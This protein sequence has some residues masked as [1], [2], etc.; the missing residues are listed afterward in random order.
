MSLERMV[1][2][3]S[4]A[5]VGALQASTWSHV[6]A[7]S[8][9]APDAMPTGRSQFLRTASRLGGGESRCDGRDRLTRYLSL[10]RAEE[11]AEDGKSGPGAD[12]S[13]H[14][15]AAT[16][17]DFTR[18]LMRLSSNCAMPASTAGRGLSRESYPGPVHCVDAS[19]RRQVMLNASWCASRAVAPI[20]TSHHRI[21][22]IELPRRA[23]SACQASPYA[24]R[25]PRRNTKVPATPSTSIDSRTKGASYVRSGPGGIGPVGG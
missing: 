24:R 25:V 11:P 21:D 13:G 14:G 7:R 19:P 6:L 20:G 15:R 3:L 22:R 12:A 18:T 1:F 10:G 8:L 2:G 4:H 9:D 5:L 23:S 17:L 16:R